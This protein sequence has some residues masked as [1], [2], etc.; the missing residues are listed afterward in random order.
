MKK[1]SL[2]VLLSLCIILSMLVIPGVYAAE[3]EMNVPSVPSDLRQ[4]VVDYATQLS[5]VEWTCPQDIDFTHAV[6]WS[7]ELYYQAGVV[8][9]GLP[10]TSDRPSANANLDE[11]LAMRGGDGTYVGPI[12][13]NDMPGSDCGGQVRL[14]YAWAG[15]LCGVEMEELVFNP[16]E[17]SANGLIPLG[18]YDVSGF[19]YSNATQKTIC[20]VN[21]DQKMYDCF[22][23]LQKGDCVFVVYA[24]GGEHIMLVTD[25]PELVTD[26]AGNYLG[27]QCRLPILELNSAIHDKGAYKS[28]WN[29]QS[30]TFKALYTMGFI[31]MTMTSYNRRGVENPTFENVNLNISGDVGFH[32]LM[33]GRVESNYNVFTLTGT[34]TD[35]AG[36]VVAQ[37][38]SYPNSL[39]A[40]LSELDYADEL[41]TLPAGDYHYTLQA[42][43]GYGTRTVVDTDI[44]YTGCEGAPV[45]FISDK[46]TGN[47][48]SPEAALGNYP[49]YEEK[50]LTSYRDSALAQALEMLSEC[51][52]TVV[53]CD[54]VTISTGRA[55]T[56]YTAA[57]SPLTAPAVRSLQSVVLTSNYGGVDYRKQNGAELIA[58]RSGAQAVCLE[59]N[60]GTVWRDLDFRMDYNYAMMPA[61]T[62]STIRAYIACFGNKTVIEDTTT[63]TISCAGKML[64]PAKNEKYYP[65][66]YGGTYNILT[67]GDTDLTVMGGNWSTV[68]GGSNS[69]YLVGGTNLTIGGKAVVYDG[70]Y[71]GGTHNDGGVS[72]NVNLNI[73]GGSVAGKLIIGGA[74]PFYTAPFDIRLTVS[75]KADLSGIR[76]VNAGGGGAAES[77]VMD[78]GDYR[79]GSS[80]TAF[81]N[82]AEFTQIIPAPAQ[83]GTVIFIAVGAVVAAGAV[84]AAV[85]LILRRKKKTVSTTEANTEK[86]N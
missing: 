26:E 80:F 28:N 58:E 27:D 67:V 51:G 63:V 62:T 41:V 45:V 3:D 39:R 55:L 7:P 43:I 46:G 13:W 59:L 38:V 19:T 23:K 75:G 85:V 53:V 16:D 83:S 78:M 36:K 34:I 11:F 32:A 8:Y 65:R 31:P 22:A 68:V 74:T 6:T 1:R 2:W 48:S 64:D 12:S 57:L 52:G 30:Y 33:S 82:E 84:A 25:A 21:G 29:D 54:D 40:D 47:G 17:S 35:R 60:I 66:L 49:H 10:Y 61:L 24:G 77:V 42:K 14:A 37:G 72:G 50:K 79:K 4:V 69:G 81:Y 86:E 9:H 76:I 70:V 5:K 18:D 20:E 71:G 56:R 73:T 15:V 44:H